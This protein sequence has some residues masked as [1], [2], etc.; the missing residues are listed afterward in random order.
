MEIIDFVFEFIV[1]VF[2]KVG[3]CVLEGSYFVGIF[4]WYLDGKLLVFNEKGVFVKEEIRRYFE[5][6]FFIL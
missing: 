3:I 4:S 1:G 6:G 5:M 2:N